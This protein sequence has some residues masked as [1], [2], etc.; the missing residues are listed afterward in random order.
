MTEVSWHTKE[1]QAAPSTIC[2]ERAYVLEGHNRKLQNLPLLGR[3]SAETES[4]GMTKRVVITNLSQKIRPQILRTSGRRLGMEAERAA[5][6]AAPSTTST[7]A[8]ID[9]AV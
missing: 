2:Y 3:L 8:Q 5:N 9:A 1:S 6:A 7:V 4:C